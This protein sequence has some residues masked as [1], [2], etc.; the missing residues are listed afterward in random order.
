MNDRT[1]HVARNSTS[2]FGRPQAH[3]HQRGRPAG[4]ARDAC[5]GERPLVAAMPI[6]FARDAF[7]ALAAGPAVWRQT[8]DG[9]RILVERTKRG[10]VLWTCPGC[11]SRTTFLLETAHEGWRCRRCTGAKYPSQC[12]S[13]T[14]RR[15]AT[16]LR[17]Q[18]RL[19]RTLEGSIHAIREARLDRWLA[20][21]DALC[22]RK[23]G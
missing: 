5:Y 8:P 23:L 11:S 14:L 9:E 19:P 15:E 18:L 6:R 22:S 17:R 16:R 4:R 20:H 1:V 3:P 13:G 7:G 2:Q 12:I 21:A 10:F